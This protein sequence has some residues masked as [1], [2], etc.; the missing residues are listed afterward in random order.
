M[1]ENHKMKEERTT[2]LIEKETLREL[3]R[4]KDYKKGKDGKHYLETYDD[5]LRRLLKWKKN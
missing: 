4:L 2:I 3:K 1:R 5:L